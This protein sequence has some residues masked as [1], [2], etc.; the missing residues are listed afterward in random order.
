MTICLWLMLTLSG[1]AVGC[2]PGYY[3]SGPEYQA[4]PSQSM[5]GMSFNNP[6][7][8]EEKTERILREGMDR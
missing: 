8:P 6:E 7:T 1:I 5:E 2:A 4:P 3:A